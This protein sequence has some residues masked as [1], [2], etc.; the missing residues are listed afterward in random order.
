MRTVFSRFFWKPSWNLAYFA[1]RALLFQV[2]L[3]IAVNLYIVS[4]WRGVIPRPWTFYQGKL[5]FRIRADRNV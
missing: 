4:R 3:L 1:L 5:Q 2:F